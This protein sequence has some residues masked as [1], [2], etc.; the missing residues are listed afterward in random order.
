MTARASITIANVDGI[1]V[2]HAA[3]TLAQLEAFS[4]A[5]GLGYWDGELEPNVTLTVYGLERTKTA[6][7]FVALTLWANGL[8]ENATLVVHENASILSAD[9]YW[10][11]TKTPNGVRVERLA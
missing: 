4:I 5:D 6:K 10:A 9:I 3:D 11:D 1:E 2:A 8:R 7:A